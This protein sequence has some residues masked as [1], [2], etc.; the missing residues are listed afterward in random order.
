MY[1]CY[2]YFNAG[3]INEN[4]KA[5]VYIFQNISWEFFPIF[6]I[7]YP[8][9]RS[10]PYHGS[11]EGSAFYESILWN[12]FSYGKLSCLKCAVCNK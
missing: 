3:A 12:N 10:K 6:C 9:P 7:F 5:E 8:L 11:L 2:M 4:N 1:F